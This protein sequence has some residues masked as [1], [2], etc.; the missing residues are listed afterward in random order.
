MYF[1]VHC[2]PITTWPTGRITA[3]LYTGSYTC[4]TTAK[5]IGNQ[6]PVSKTRILAFEIYFK[7][8]VRLFIAESKT[9]PETYEITQMTYV[10]SKNQYLV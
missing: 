10:L 6:S 3:T 9:R 8:S 1:K 4:I 5:S 2:L 7:K